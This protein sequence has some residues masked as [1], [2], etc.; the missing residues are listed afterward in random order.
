MLCC[1]SCLNLMLFCTSCPAS[2]VEMKRKNKGWMEEGG[3]LSFT[4]MIPQGSTF[5]A[6]EIQATTHHNRPSSPTAR[7]QPHLTPS[8]I[9]RKE[10]ARWQTTQRVKARPQ[11]ARAHHGTLMAPLSLVPHHQVRKDPLPPP[12]PSLRHYAAPWQPTNFPRSCS[13]PRVAKPTLRPSAQVRTAS[14]GTGLYRTSA[15]PQPVQPHRQL[16]E[17]RIEVSGQHLLK[18][19]EQDTRACS[20]T[21]NAA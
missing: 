11:P 9:W 20:Q 13:R 10:D 18:R 14:S 7:H 4:P 17:R 21:S 6:W 5:K 8:S 15:L 1:M 12:N 16:R 3:N 2:Y 19:E